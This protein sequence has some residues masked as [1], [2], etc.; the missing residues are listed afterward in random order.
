MRS[1]LYGVD[2]YDGLTLAAVVFIL[3]CATLAATTLPVL[4]ITSIDPA[5]TLR[6]E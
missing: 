6:E 5:H 4:K 3:V 2:V 1:L